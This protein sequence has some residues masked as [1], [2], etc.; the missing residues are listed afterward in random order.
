MKEIDLTQGIEYVVNQGNSQQKPTQQRVY[1]T[2]DSDEFV[3]SQ[4]TNKKKKV[5]KILA[6]LTAAAGIITA[7]YFAIRR[8]KVSVEDVER[9][10]Q[11]AANRAGV[12]EE[13]SAATKG[14]GEVVQEVVSGI[15]SLKASLVT[16]DADL[17]Q[18]QEIDLASFKGK[19]EID[20]DFARYKANLEEQKVSTYAIK[21]ESGKV[22]GYYQLEPAENSELYIHS[23]AVRPELQKTK[24]SLIKSK[25]ATSIVS[26]LYILIV[27]NASCRFFVTFSKVWQYSSISEIRSN[28]SSS[29]KDF[30]C[31]LVKAFNPLLICATLTLL[32]SEIYF[33]DNFSLSLFKSSAF[34][35]N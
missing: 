8:G 7:G 26:I 31:N 29:E 15:K 9:T 16:D 27:S 23:I 18:V 21:D 11:E 28:A 3:S 33:S 32:I 5:K 30:I 22:V 19:Y 17:R 13:V 35:Q 10:V 14:A 25:S 1:M 12:S 4:G 20:E 24:T 34:F 6:G 2:T